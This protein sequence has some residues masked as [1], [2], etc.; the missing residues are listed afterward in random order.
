MGQNRTVNKDI[1]QLEESYLNLIYPPNFFESFES[2]DEL[3]DWLNLDKPYIKDVIQACEPHRELRW[4]I[5]VCLEE[6]Y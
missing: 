5:D 1:E 3:R 4:V 2:K 6:M